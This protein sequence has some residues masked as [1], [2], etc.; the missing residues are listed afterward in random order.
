MREIFN[1]TVIILCILYFLSMFLNPQLII[2]STTK[3]AIIWW[4]KVLP[5]IFPYFLVINVLIESKLI[6]YLS[7]IF[8]LPSKKIFKLSSNGFLAMIIGM[9]TGY[10]V[11]AKMVCNLYS[12][13]LISKNE[14]VRLLYFVNNSGPLFI[15]GTVGINLLGFKKYG[16][17][18]FFAHILASLIIALCT[19]RFAQSEILSASAPYKLLNFDIGKVLSKSVKDSVESILIIGGFITLFFNLNNVLE[20]FKI[21]HSICSLF[22]FTG[23]DDT[24]IKGLLYGLFEITNGSVQINTNS[25]PV[26]QKLIA[27][28]LIISWGGLSVHFQTISFLSVAGL[29]SF[30]YIIGKL[31][32]CALATAII[33]VFLIILP[34]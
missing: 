30:H 1:F 10:P 20:Y 14:A 12:Q 22:R 21:Y 26:W 13:K 17:M 11:G 18:L 23:A 15:I 19:S 32:Q 3:S 29:Q 25:L 31:I 24:L 34:L 28:E 33:C 16:Y 27:S 9:L 6:S 2:Q 7:S 8:F 5:S 4:E